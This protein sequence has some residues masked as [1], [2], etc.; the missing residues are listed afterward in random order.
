MEI[1]VRHQ[2]EAPVLISGTGKIRSLGSELSSVKCHFEQPES[3]RL[4]RPSARRAACRGITN[5]QPS[6]DALAKI[7]TN[8]KACG[9][10][11]DLCVGVY[12][13]RVCVR[14]NKWV[15][16]KCVCNVTLA[17]AV[18]CANRLFCTAQREV[19]CVLA[20]LGE[21]FGWLV[22]GGAW[23]AGGFAASLSGL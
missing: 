10:C 7:T 1:G 12:L 5:P 15:L 21:A 19:C 9:F 3:T 4:P 13:T 23:G 2:H 17:V 20:V 22:V 14:A 16:D 8:K 6:P 18:H 11:A